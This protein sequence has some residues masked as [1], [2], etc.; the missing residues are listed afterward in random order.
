MT[1]ILFCLYELPFSETNRIPFK[2][3]IFFVLFQIT[4]PWCHKNNP[5][6][7]WHVAPDWFFLNFQLGTSHQSLLATHNVHVCVFSKSPI[8]FNLPLPTKLIFKSNLVSKLWQLYT[9]FLAIILLNALTRTSK[10]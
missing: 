8:N 6:C 1:L 5:N 9:Y 4:M 7:I 10:K 3:S 2:L